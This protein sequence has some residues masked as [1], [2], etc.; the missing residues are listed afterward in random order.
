MKRKKKKKRKKRRR[1]K[2]KKKKKKNVCET[3][4]KVSTF[5]QK[6]ILQYTHTK[7]IK[8]GDTQTLVIQAHGNMSQQFKCG[9]TRN[10]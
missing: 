2:R 7:R 3:G 6:C 1:K 5:S 4:R 10:V 8:N 9:E